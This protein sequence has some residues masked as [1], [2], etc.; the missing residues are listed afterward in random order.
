MSDAK[1]KLSIEAA[2]YARTIA[3]LEGTLAEAKAKY[4][5]LIHELHSLEDDQDYIDRVGERGE[6]L[7]EMSE[8]YKDDGHFKL[9]KGAVTSD[10]T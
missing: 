2:A 8:R 4:W 1:T 3:H 7:A 10:D 9:A 6:T 5:M